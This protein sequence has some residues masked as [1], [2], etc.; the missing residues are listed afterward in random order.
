LALFATPVRA[1]EYEIFVDA[2]DEEELYDLFATNQI[3]E[4]TFNTLVELHRRGVDLNTAT[5]EELYAL[6]NLTFEDVDAILQYRADTGYITSPATLVLAKVLDRRKLGS[7]AMYLVVREPGRALS[8]T[9]GMI[10]AQTAWSVE[11]STA[12]PA[13]MQARVSTARHLTVGASIF[14]TRLRLGD[15]R[16]DPARE[17]MSATDVGSRAHVPKAFAEWDGDGWGVIAGS[18]RI[19]F[20][21]RLTFDNSGRFTPNGFYFDDSVF[22]S[23]SLTREC[24]YSTGELAESPCTGA[25]GDV[26]VTP[27]FRWRDGL[28]GAAVGFDHAKLPVG[29]LQ[30]YAWASYQNHGIY[31]YELYDR[32]A[33]DDPRNDDDDRCS[34]PDVYVR[35]PADPL[36]SAPRFAFQTLPNMYDQALGGA[37]FS[38]FHARRTHVG[39]TGYGAAPIWRVEGA[40]LDFQEWASTPFGGP[41]GAVGADAAWGHR[42]ADL[43][44]EVARSVDSMEP[45]EESP[46]GGG[47]AGILR[48]TATWKDNELELAAR[49][50]DTAY[51]NPF[52][53]PINAPD[54][55]DGNRS[56]DE[57]GIRLRYNGLVA[58]R[59]SLRS[60]ADFWLQPTEQQPKTLAFVRGDVKATEWFYPGLWLQYRNKD[61]RSFDSVGQCFEVSVEFDENGE[62]IPC[63]GQQFQI[64]PRL[65]FKPHKRVSFTTQYQHEWLDDPAYDDRRRQDASAWLIFSTNPWKTLRFRARARYRF[66]DISD[67]ARLEQSLWSYLEGSYKFA[68]SLTL[69]LRY[70]LLVWLDER[71]ST[72]DRIPSPEHWLRLQLEARF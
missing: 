6:P 64:T 58:D 20:G 45:T 36:A 3:S 66:E 72:A 40:D 31:Q 27:D 63:G 68:N 51:A 48:G 35:D 59:L 23:A 28:R 9:N 50:Y 25:A 38:W 37:N 61:L 42:W 43:F 47:W 69:R 53:R 16:W 19:G 70:D 7:I 8:A 60:S 24:R 14:H 17:A 32:N 65:G 10:R 22:R 33:C 4:D 15:V 5:R 54:E 11:D 2:D 1:A 26:Y 67:N 52:A 21:Q 49:Y 44:A 62:P 13:V 30:G 39:V 34:A 57:A 18:Y 46:G 29:W 55:F 41:Y 12:P 56:R 71:S